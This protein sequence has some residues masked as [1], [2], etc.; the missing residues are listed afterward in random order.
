[1]QSFGNNVTL[2]TYHCPLF[3]CESIMI[4]FM[5]VMLFW[6]CDAYVTNVLDIH[7]TKGASTVCTMT[8]I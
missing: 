1:M 4:T 5:A 2:C 7:D 8:L 6:V 3:E